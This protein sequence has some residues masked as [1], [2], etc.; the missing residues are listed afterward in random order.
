M[1]YTPAAITD[2]SVYNDLI[3]HCKLIV[4]YATNEDSPRPDSDGFPMVLRGAGMPDPEA[5]QAP[6]LVDPDAVATSDLAPIVNYVLVIARYFESIFQEKTG[7]SGVTL[8]NIAVGTG[9]TA[10]TDTLT[11]IRTELAAIS[12]YWNANV[13]ALQAPAA[14]LATFP[15]LP[16]P[17]ALV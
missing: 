10:V 8:A 11:A 1:P 6:R 13:A 7:A 16:T 5:H 3:G 17:L 9:A 14:E 15:T 4:A 12:T 2:A